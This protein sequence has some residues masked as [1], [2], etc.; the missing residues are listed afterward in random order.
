MPMKSY[1]SPKGPGRCWECNA[2]HSSREECRSVRW[3]LLS[4]CDAVLCV[5]LISSVICYNTLV[6]LCCQLYRLRV[7][8]TEF[9]SLFAPREHENQVLP[10]V[11]L[12]KSCSDVTCAQAP[13]LGKGHTGPAYMNDPRHPTKSG[14]GSRCVG[15]CG[16]L[17]LPHTLHHMLPHIIRYTLLT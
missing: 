11:K 12:P 8:Y 10:T 7:V 13:P 3:I 5:V 6:M 16:A 4:F 9:N 1:T 2:S 14:G 17:W 15:S